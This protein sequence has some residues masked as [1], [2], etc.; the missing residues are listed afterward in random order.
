MLSER[1]LT[2]RAELA[3]F[4]AG[5][6]GQGGLAGTWLPAVVMLLHVRDAKRDRALL[7]ERVLTLRAELA[8]LEAGL[9]GQGGLAGAIVPAEVVLLH[10]R[11]AKRFRHC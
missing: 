7:S 11:D 6:P 4:E 1:A 5:L 2:L 3:A 10:G 9:P 8:I